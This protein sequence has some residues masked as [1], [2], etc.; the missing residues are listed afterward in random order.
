MPGRHSLGAWLLATAAMAM[1]APLPAAADGAGVSLAIGETAS[2]V[3]APHAAR[4]LRRA[5]EEEL[6]TTSGVELLSARR[7]QW[8]VRGS[9]TRLDRSRDDRGVTVVRC[10]VSLLVADRRGGAVRMLLTG[11]AGARSADE[12]VARL[13]SQALRAAVRGAIRPL[14]TTLI[15]MR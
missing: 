14:G 6:A 15:A 10:E 3:S 1:C 7:A 4:A 8:I 11:R 9:V 12:E 13:E 5:L 2:T